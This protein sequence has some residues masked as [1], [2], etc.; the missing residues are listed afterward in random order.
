MQKSKIGTLEAIML[1]LTIIVTHTILS[2]PNDILTSYKSAS[3]L[4]VIY[5]SML[6]ILIAY[7]IFR[8]FKNFPG[9]DIIDISEWM[10]GKIFKNIVGMIFIAYFIISAS[11]LLRNFCESIKIIYYPMTNIVFIIAFFVIAICIANRFELNATL[12]TNLV[13]LPIVLASMVFLFFTNIYK[14]SPQ[15][16]FPILGDGMVNTFV[17]GISNLASFG[18]IAYLYFLP[19]LLAKPEKFK[20]VALV[21]IGITALYLLLS[22]STLLFMFSFFIS[23][24][25]ISPLYNATRY[26]ELGSFFQRLESLFL[27]I[28]V[29][30]FACYLSIVTKFSMNIFKKLTHI[31]TTKP[32]LDIFGLLILSIAL[33]PKNF[34]I[35]QK[36]ESNVYPYFVLGIV[37][38]LGIGILVIANFRKR[39]QKKFEPQSLERIDKK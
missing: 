34:A 30:A 18:G 9:L 31:D 33:I 1:I 13:I 38:V 4:N 36:F 7:C 19:P 11:L 10:G 28:W 32:L 2:L 35:S 29:L 14:F 3:I 15:R 20:K 8:L 22:V 26:I 21:S 25:E 6:A 24:S 39:K 5:V 27:L 16:I 23:S 37:L 17:L 12:K